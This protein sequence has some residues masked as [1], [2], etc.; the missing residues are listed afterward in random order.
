M[1]TRKSGIPVKSSNG[2]KAGGVSPSGSQARPSSIPVK[3][4][5]VGYSYRLARDYIAL[6]QHLT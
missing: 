2:S 6:Y 5:K 3:K 1:A 4:A